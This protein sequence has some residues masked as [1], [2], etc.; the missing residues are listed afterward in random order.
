M[1][2]SVDVRDDT[3]RNR[4]V[5]QDEGVEA[6]LTYRQRAG[7]LILIHT[8]VPDVLGGRG[9]GGRLVRSAI[10]KAR[11]EHLTVVPLCPFARRWL[12]EH[13]AEATGVS[14]DWETL[15]QREAADG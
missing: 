4:L 13:P 11:D 10:E 7:R 12:G 9:V 14:I 5:I 2:E 8:G 3:E 1:P 15:E 6:E